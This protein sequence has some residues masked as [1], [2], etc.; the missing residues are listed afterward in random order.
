VDEELTQG[1]PEG[2]P[3]QTVQP[4]AATEAE[5]L[6]LKNR[7]ETWRVPKDLAQQVADHL[8][9]DLNR[10]KDTIE[11]GSDGR[12]LYSR[13]D[14]ERERLAQE[15]HQLRAIREQMEQSRQQYQP[16]QPQY[17]PAYTQQPGQ[18]PM[19]TP[20]PDPRD[21]TGTL[22][23]QADMMER[24]APILERIPEIERNQQFINQSIGQREEM[25]ETAEERS[26]AIRA[27]ADTAERWEKEFGVKPPPQ[28]E[29]EAYLRTVTISDDVNKSWN[30]IWDEAAWAVSGPRVYRQARRQA[31][32]AAQQPEAR[33]T[34]PGNRVAPAAQPQMNMGTPQTQEELDAQ[35][36][37][38]SRA[39]GSMT[40][41][42]FQ[43][44]QR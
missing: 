4:E 8:G 13:V 44:G 41:Q 42:D 10:L 38:M 26:V 7:D 33:L 29:L 43:N 31:V 12:Q 36:N 17:A 30:Q 27:Y 3:E 22:L 16:Q 11:I 19:A 1:T 35:F 39:V 24:L 15:A 37:Q 9:W 2:Q 32:L 14:E 5:Y 18:R 25:R 6:D 20:R 21:V 28:R 34:V 23:W 40:L